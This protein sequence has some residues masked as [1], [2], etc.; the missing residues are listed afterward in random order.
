[1][2]SDKHAPAS[3]SS[4]TTPPSWRCRRD[5]RLTFDTPRLM[6]IL[7]LTPDSFSDGGELPTVEAAV[8]RARQFAD[9]GADVL[10]VGGESTR[11]GAE[12]I[13][14]E[15]QIR[16][17]VPAIRAIRDAGLDLPITIDTTLAVVAAAALDAGADAINDVSAGTDD[18]RI[19]DLAGE[20]GA[21]LILMHRV[22]PP[23][24]DVYSHQYARAPVAGDIV[25]VVRAG[26]AEHLAGARAAGVEEEAIVLDPGL[27][28]GK[29]VEQN[30]ALMRRAAELAHLGRPL[31]L[32][33]S[34]K[35]FLGKLAGETEPSRRDVASALATALMRRAG[36]AFFRVHTV[37][38]H[39]QALRLADAFAG[40]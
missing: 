27:G 20:S 14:A 3:P 38:M 35:S 1:M 16:R 18:P 10:D 36:A 5:R 4:A 32:G 7:N 23:E 25:N 26:L 19:L 21:G 31:L 33:A 24:R 8:G 22:L 28:F 30:L 11:P 39:R 13:P 15:E 2:P 17:V 34:R 37:A 9:E 6:A 12:R 29:S 40:A